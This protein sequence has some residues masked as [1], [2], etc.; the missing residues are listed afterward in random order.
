MPEDE[1]RIH[2]RQLTD[3][4][5]MRALA[6]PSRVALWELLAVHGPMTAT[7]AAEHV[8]DSP[9]NC[10]F[11]LRQLA[12]YGLVEEADDVTSTGRARPWRVTE[13][14]YSITTE[15]DDSIDTAVAA[16]ALS[17]VVID[18]AVDRQKEWQRRARS[19]DE[20]WRQIAGVTQTVWWVT[21]AEATELRTE[22]NA[23]VQRFQQRLTEP[24]TRPYEAR[25][26]E[27]LALV[28]PF[29]NEEQ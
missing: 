15:P 26:V 17:T 4:R 12:K 16:E 27:F 14:G 8:D 3:A 1:T 29:D 13:I 5:T 20:A 22:I 21:E 25:P 9:S 18:R 7:Q 24:S 11:H 6:H 23:L 2:R 19:T 28:H 10:S